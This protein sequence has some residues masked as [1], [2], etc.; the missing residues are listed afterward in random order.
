M[1]R[2]LAFG[3]CLGLALYL[4]YFAFVQLRTQDVRDEPDGPVMT[5]AARAKLLQAAHDLR[6]GDLDR[7]AQILL[8]SQ[9]REFAE[10]ETPV[11]AMGRHS[12][13]FGLA[14][15]E[16]HLNLLEQIQEVLFAE[17]TSNSN[18]SLPQRAEGLLLAIKLERHLEKANR[19]TNAQQEPE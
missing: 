7:E 5:G 15:E 14:W 3:G 10:P 19:R 12:E 11:A 16:R 4:L 1:G 13:G 17:L 2:F 9:L 8:A 6:N 18:S